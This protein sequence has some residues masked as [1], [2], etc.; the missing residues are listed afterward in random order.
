MRSWDLESLEHGRWVRDTGHLDKGDYVSIIGFQV[1]L[2]SNCGG[3]ATSDDP[4]VPLLEA[5]VGAADAK[6]HEGEEDDGA[7]NQQDLKLTK[8]LEGSDW[9]FGKPEEL[10]F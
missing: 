4:D 9:I 6:Q 1:Y 5:V 10:V 8:G 3:R 7:H 2:G